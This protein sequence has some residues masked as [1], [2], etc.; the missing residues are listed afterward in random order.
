[1]RKAFSSKRK[2]LSPE[3]KAGTPAGFLAMLPC[4]QC[5]ESPMEPLGAAG[6]R[7]KDGV[8]CGEVNQEGQE[9]RER[10]DDLRVGRDDP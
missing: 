7:E 10:Q 8:P 3:R 4:D 6:E 9:V 1:M 2:R 5:G